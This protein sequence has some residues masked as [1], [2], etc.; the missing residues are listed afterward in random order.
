MEVV[1]ILAIIKNTARRASLA[2]LCYRPVVKETTC[3][4]SDL[5]EGDGQWSWIFLFLLQEV[6]TQD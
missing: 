6:E 4:S 5:I 1:N 3:V 2:A